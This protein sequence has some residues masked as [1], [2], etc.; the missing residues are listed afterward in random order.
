M[1][2]ELCRTMT[3]DGLE[4]HGFLASPEGAVPEWGVIHIHG[5]AGNFYENRFIENITRTVV[6]LGGA[7]LTVNTRGRD[8][9]SD[10]ILQKPDGTKE[11]RQIGGTYE[12]FE[13]CVEDIGAW[14]AYLR[15]RGTRHVILQGHSHGALKVTYYLYRESDPRVAG[16]ILLSPSDD[17]GCQR[18]KLGS[19]FAEAVE[20]ARTMVGSG[21]GADLIP[22]GYYHYPVSAATYLDIFDDGSKLKSFNLSRTDTQE[23]PELRSI[24]V[25]VLTIVGSV[26]EFFL[27]TP[28]RY[29]S[30]IEGELKNAPGFLGGVIDGAPHNYL[31]FEEEVAVHIGKWLNSGV[32]E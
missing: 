31:D 9:L 13:E 32:V 30:L 6:N 15:S 25:P 3:E 16:L 14:I 2:G 28:G 22:D 20:A 29:L 1:Q 26:E 19:R 24:R 23:F 27:E 21:R 8:Y 5:L 4:L 10:F 7:F 12:I 17:F 11:Y 18:S